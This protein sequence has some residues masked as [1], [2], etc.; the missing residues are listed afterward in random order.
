MVALLH[1]NSL[2]DHLTS[3]AGVLVIALI[4]AVV[5]GVFTYA[6]R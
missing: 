6:R 1:H 4:V 3:A 5:L 2:T